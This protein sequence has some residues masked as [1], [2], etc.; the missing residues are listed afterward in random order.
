MG[1][2]RTGSL[3]PDEFAWEEAAPHLERKRKEITVAEGAVGAHSE[4]DTDSED[5]V[6]CAAREG[7]GECHGGGCLCTVKV[8]DLCP[9]VQTKVT[10]EQHQDLL[11]DP[12][13]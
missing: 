4:N 2:V 12:P 1:T 3:S 6:G 7:S 11:S 9:T 10:N 8:W 13:A 5:A